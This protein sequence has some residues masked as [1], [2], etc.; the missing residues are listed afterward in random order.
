MAAHHNPAM[1]S[2]TAPIVP[3]SHEAEQAVVGGLMLAPK[4]LASICDWIAPGD[5]YSRYHAEIY[6]G[7]L[8]LA[9]QS[10]PFD[11]VTLGE[12]FEANLLSEQ[13]GGRGYLIDL[14]SNTPSAANIVAYAEIVAE[15]AKLRSLITIGTDLVNAAF[16]PGAEARQVA[17]EGG[18][19]LMLL[20]NASTLGG[21]KT[22][23]EVGKVWFDEISRRVA[24]D[25]SLLGLPTPWHGFNEK[26][27]GL[28]KGE[29]IIVAGRPG[30]GKSAWANNVAELNALAA[31][32]TMIFNLEMTGSAIYN[33]MVGSMMDIP[34]SWFKHPKHEDATIWQRVGL[35][36]GNLA[37]AALLIDDS[38][39]LTIDQITARA[40]REHMRQPVELVIVDHLHII[41]LPGKTRETVEIGHITS[42][43]K[44]LAKELNCPVVL[45]A[46]LNRSLEARP[47]TRP[48]MSDLRESGNIEQDADVILFLYRDDYYAEQ[49]QRNSEYPGFVEM[50]IAKSREG[51]TGKAWGRN[52]LAFGKIADHHGDPPDKKNESDSE[53]KNKPKKANWSG[54]R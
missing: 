28:C 3:Q 1:P 13:M 48:R 30:M 5:F 15:K 16:S 42:S 40:R 10:Q 51:E 45:L 9:E 36:V 24:D 52:H 31:H 54:L 53:E 17:A 2:R 43:L 39:G 14:A 29:L 22:I 18:R 6:R 35:G 26:T 4:A 44:R 25:G 21:P 23:K 49:E 32:Q 46:Q 37:K 8:R 12:W 7:I 33:R 11:A 27:S 34:L 47:N 41:P 50:I 19:S 38:P 20:G